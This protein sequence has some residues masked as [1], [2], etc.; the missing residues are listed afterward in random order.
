MGL[1]SRL[2]VFRVQRFVNEYREEPLQ[3]ALPGATLQELWDTMALAQRALLGVSVLV[4]LVGLSGMVATLLTSLNERRREMAVLRAVGARPRHIFALLVGEAGAI[5]AIATSAAL[6]LL[7]LAQLL[8]QPLVQTHLGL[9]LP[10]RPPSPYELTL[11]GAALAGG[12]LV[13]TLPAY[14]AYRQTLADGLMIRT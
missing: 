12:V 14:L 9:Y 13:G 11:L 1:Q 10:I 3:A 5:M 6:A 7:Y 8:L 4:V 2:G